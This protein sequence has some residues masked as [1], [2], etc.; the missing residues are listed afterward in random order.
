MPSRCSWRESPARRRERSS[1][2]RPMRRRR[3]WWPQGSR[4][5]RR[6][7]G[8]RKRKMGPGSPGER[9]REGRRRAIRRLPAQKTRW[10]G[11]SVPWAS[12]SARAAAGTIPQASAAARPRLRSET[13]RFSLMS[14]LLLS[15]AEP[16]FSSKR[17]CCRPVSIPWPNIPLRPVSRN[18][19]RRGRGWELA[20]PRRKR[21]GREPCS[22]PRWRTISRSISC[23]S[24]PC[25]GGG[26]RRGAPPR[27]PGHRPRAAAPRPGARR[28]SGRA[29]SLIHI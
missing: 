17:D 9:R 23:P 22:R 4:P 1:P 16:R 8:S 21:R 10:G 29:L 27:P 20:Q 3:G 15:Q 14:D 11:V 5:R 24:A 6:R 28:R 18:P 26:G 13:A 7:L 25:A 19:E 2:R 12:G